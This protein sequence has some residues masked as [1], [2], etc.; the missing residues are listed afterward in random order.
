MIRLW[1]RLSATRGQPA[2]ADS[3]RFDYNQ[4]AFF[5]GV[6]ESVQVSQEQSELCA[7]PFGATAKKDY[8]GL[9]L[10]PSS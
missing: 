9:V 1:H 10:L 6:G 8:R 3:A 2:D 7:G 4:A 5:E